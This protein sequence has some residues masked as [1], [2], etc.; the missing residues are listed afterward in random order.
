[1]TIDLVKKTDPTRPAF[2]SC[3][4]PN[5]IKDQAW[6]DDH[7][8]GPTTVDQI[9]ANAKWGA[10]FSE[11]PHIFYQKET[12]DYDP[13]ASDLWSEALMK[14]WDKLWKD[15]TILGSFIWEWQNQG[16]ADKYPTKRAISGMAQITAPG[17]QQGHRDRPI[18]SPSPNGGS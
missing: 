1:M 11:H 16:I 7:Y 10:N 5:D 14:T 4:S 3:V 15:P 2:V 18:A 17:E 9:A 12:Q 8:P 13:G 6:E